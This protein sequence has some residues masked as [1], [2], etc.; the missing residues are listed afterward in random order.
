M[1]SRGHTGR[2][3]STL[4]IIILVGIL[5]LL[6]RNFYEASHLHT[7]HFVELDNYSKRDILFDDEENAANMINEIRGDSPDLD[8][9]AEK[10]HEVDV[11]TGGEEENEDATDV[12]K[13]AEPQV[14]EEKGSAATEAA[15]NEETKGGDKVEEKE[16]PAAIGGA[17]ASI[18]KSVNGRKLG[19][20]QCEKHGGAD[21]KVVED[22]V[23]WY[24][25]P[26]DSDYVNPFQK[27]NIE[28]G[29]E[30]FFIFEK[31]PAGFNNFRMSLE[32]IVTTGIAMGRTIVLPPEQPMYLWNSN[33]KNHKGR[34]SFYDFYHLTAIREEHPTIKI[35]T[36]QE[37]LDQAEKEGLFKDKETGKVLEVPKPEGDQSWDR[38]HSGEVDELYTWL[39][40]NSYH[41][42]GFDSNSC[43]MY[44]PESPG[45]NTTEEEIKIK[46]LMQFNPMPVRKDFVDKPIPVNA[47]LKERMREQMVSGRGLCAYNEEMQ[48]A[49]IL[50]STHVWDPGNGKEQGNR[51]LSPFYTFHFYEDWKQDLWTKRFVRDHF[52]YHDE[53]ICAAARVVAAIRSRVRSRGHAD[54]HN[55]TFN[56]GTPQNSNICAIF[57]LHLIPTLFPS[58]HIRKGD[59]KE[60]YEATQI[61]AM[62]LYNYSE[63]FLQKNSTLF[64]ATDHRDKSFFAPFQKNYDV[65]FLDDFKEEL[66]GINSNYF[67]ILDQVIASKGD[68]FVGT[69]W[70]TLSAYVNRMRGYYSIRDKLKGYENGALK[71]FYFM[72]KHKQKVMRRYF[73]PSDGLWAHEF[74]T[75]WRNIDKME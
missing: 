22:M 21:Q 61:S 14:E 63:S 46:S 8:E 73:P 25:V 65:V 11:E 28:K 52:R 1:N 69:F 33:N 13:N 56:T 70:S 43:F 53:I 32:T 47:S 49:Q 34:F 17:D 39:S 48:N 35:I 2:S 36:M 54:S 20:V 19:N 27:R 51:F 58:V 9:E 16:E 29:Q 68:V 41:M 55:A 44:W 66:K 23:Y 72:P 30:Q 12:K 15:G 40:K 38:V 50:V 45:K 31:D 74:P 4:H 64:I 3:L 5:L 42:S 71:S 67:G 59:F 62:E 37:F 7:H 26:S 6:L 75:A 18:K 60:Q 10:V 57:I 24:D